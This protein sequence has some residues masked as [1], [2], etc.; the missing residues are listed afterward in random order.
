MRALDDVGGDLARFSHVDVA[1]AVLV[2]SG[3]DAAGEPVVV[4]GTIAK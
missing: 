2:F 4:S 1:K 3:V